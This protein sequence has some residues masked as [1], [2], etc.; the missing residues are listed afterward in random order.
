MWRF[1]DA[2]SLR[3]ACVHDVTLSLT[4]SHDLLRACN[5]FSF[6]LFFH[7]M[8]IFMQKRTLTPFNLNSP[9][10]PCLSYLAF[11]RFFGSLTAKNLFAAFSR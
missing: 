4:L 5:A 10:V 9:L 11:P 7:D 8:I 2:S 1:R 6:S 3:H